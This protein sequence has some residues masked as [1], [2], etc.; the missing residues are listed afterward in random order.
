MSEKY[1]KDETTG[2]Y[3]ELK[4]YGNR[5]ME[6]SLEDAYEYAD[7]LNTYKY[8]G[9]SDWRV[10]AIEELITLCSIE[11][12]KYNGDYK[13]WRAWFEGIKDMSNNGFFIKDP[14]SDNLGKDGWYW[15][16]TKA[17]NGEYYLLN[18]K[19]ANTNTHLPNQ[20]FYVRCVRG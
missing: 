6:Y 18:F 14:L 4:T 8:G 9:Y 7:E 11:P 2:L 16:S 3:W 20:T 19:E 5:R 17:D 13:A 1:Y 12:Y 10:P 15:S